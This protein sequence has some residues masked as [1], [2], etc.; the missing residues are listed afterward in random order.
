MHTE[1]QRER[2]R[3]NLPK[4]KR[5]S[6]TLQ[7]LARLQ[8]TII[9]G[10][11]RNYLPQW[12]TM[13]HICRY[14]QRDRHGKERERDRKSEGKAEQGERTI[15][16]PMPSGC[17]FRHFRQSLVTKVLTVFD[18]VCPNLPGTYI[19]NKYLY[20]HTHT[21]T[22]TH[23]QRLGEREYVCIVVC[24][25]LWNFVDSSALS[26]CLSRF[27]AE[28][29]RWHIFTRLAYFRSKFARES[30]FVHDLLVLYSKSAVV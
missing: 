25:W 21:H 1:R 4:C 15:V 7:G 28:F 22:Y 26:V 14:S 2:G 10:L 8:W 20:T 9:I 27:P 17:I 5:D 3:K 6:S 18:S 30:I 29:S 23:T 24:N 11:N 16:V 13:R 12:A 19:P